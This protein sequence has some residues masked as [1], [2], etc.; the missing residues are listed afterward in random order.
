MYTAHAATPAIVNKTP[1]ADAWPGWNTTSTTPA[2]AAPA[3]SATGLGTLSRR[4]TTAMP[5]MRTGSRAHNSTD[6]LASTRANPA[7]LNAYA[8]PGLSTPSADR[9]LISGDHPTRCRRTNIA[10]AR[11]ATLTVSSSGSKVSGSISSTARL[12]TTVAPPQH[13]AATTNDN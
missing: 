5:R 1:E 6:T 4:T 2:K 10:V 11:T 3:H 13:A 8:R 12:E 7:R 9:R